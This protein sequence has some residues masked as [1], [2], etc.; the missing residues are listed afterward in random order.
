MRGSLSSWYSAGSLSS[1]NSDDILLSYLHQLVLAITF[2]N[3]LVLP[4]TLWKIFPESQWFSTFINYLIITLS[5]NSFITLMRMRV[6]NHWLLIITSSFP[7]SQWLN[8][9]VIG[10]FNNYINESAESLPL[11]NNGISACKPETKSFRHQ[12][13]HESQD[14]Y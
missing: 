8:S 7:E 10:T 1:W 14:S 4:P 2:M 9:N 6:L 13:L 3:Y 5:V 12:Y 11:N